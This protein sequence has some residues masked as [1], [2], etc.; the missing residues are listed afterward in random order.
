MLG[1][2]FGDI[3]GSVY[4]RKNTK[5]EDFPLLSKWSH[6]TDDSMMTLAVARALMN[7]WGR[8]DDEIRAELVRSMQDLGRRYPNAGY[9]RTFA[10]WL[11]E[12]NPLPYNSFGNGIAMRVSPAG[13]LYQT[14]EDTLHAA[15]LT[16][17]VSHNHPEGIKGA[18]AI[19]ASVF[20]ARAGATKEEILIYAAKTYGESMFRT[21]EAIRPGYK[22]DVSCQGSV[23]EAIIAFYESEDYEDAV[24][25]A[26]SIGG[27]SDTIAC[28]AGAIAEAFYGM[29]GKLK[30]KA[31]QILDPYCTEIAGQFRQFCR[32]HDRS[33]QEGWREEIAPKDPYE[34]L[35]NNWAIEALLDR[36][37][38]K[39]EKG[40][41]DINILPIFSLLHFCIQEGGEFLVP[42]DFKPGF[43]T[44][45]SEI[46]PGDTYTAGEDAA[47]SLK[48]IVDNDDNLSL[49]VFTSG[50]EF[51]KGEP[52]SMISLPMEQCMQL[53]LDADYLKSM[54]INPYG[55]CFIMDRETL[56]RFLD[57]IHS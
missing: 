9:G 16:A 25:K 34:S 30:K 12:K 28:M 11:Y 4:E 14:L 3:V 52:A 32:E 5:R 24:R 36:I 55:N 2:I 13:W 21:L 35:K 57:L 23:P 27:D 20:L 33:V 49:P 22:F 47:F 31:L 37:Y 38:Q 10:G 42:I 26:V 19:A 51:E 40:E 56:K 53:A 29:P 1:A 48:H 39:R 6:P 7:T 18:Q 15:A 54:V 50:S 8:S 41:T 45:P 43:P 44:S 46:R 17:E